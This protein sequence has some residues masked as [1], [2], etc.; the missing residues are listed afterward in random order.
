MSLKDLFDKLSGKLAERGFAERRKHELTVDDLIVMKQYD[1]AEIR[2]QEQIRKKASDLRS[3]LQLADLYMN[4]GRRHQAVEEYVAI[5]DGYTRDGFYDKAIALLSKVSKLVPDDETTR[6]KIERIR[7]AKR[8]EHRRSAVSEALLHG[9]AGRSG[10]GKGA[11]QFQQFWHKLSA[12]HLVERLSDERLS[13]LF[14]ALEFTQLEDGTEVACKGQRLD[15][16]YIVADGGVEAL[17]QLSGDATTV[18]R[19]LEPGDVFGERALLEHKAWP[20]TYRTNARTTLLKLT[21]ESLENALIGDSDPRRLL[22]ALR[23]Q[24]LDAQVA[25][26]ESN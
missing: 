23:E 15:E 10:S 12:C 4:S 25:A 22:E 2:L 6:L 16:L 11:F 1:E 20:A 13:R 18:I 7:R 3:R 14:A 9:V 24:G 5:A 21:R 17:L 26:S 19:A 8:L